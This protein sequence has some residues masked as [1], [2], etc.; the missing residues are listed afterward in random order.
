M[1]GRLN[2]YMWHISPGWAQVLLWVLI[3]VSALLWVVAL[4]NG[5][6]WTQQSQ[7]RD[8]LDSQVHGRGVP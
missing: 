2:E 4:V 6:R 7:A 5:L 1:I 8:H 3:A